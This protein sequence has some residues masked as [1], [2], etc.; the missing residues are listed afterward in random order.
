MRIK[1]YWALRKARRHLK[2]LRTH[3]R[4]LYHM[5][6]DVVAPEVAGTVEPDLTL[7][8]VGTV[9]NAATVI[10]ALHH[11]E[12]RLVFA[13]SRRTVETLAE[14]LRDRHTETFVSHSSLSVDERRRA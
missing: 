5:R 6:R 7:D 8:Y 13:D 14:G 11:G 4:G 2:D 9:D 3:A 1:A 12:K 10:S